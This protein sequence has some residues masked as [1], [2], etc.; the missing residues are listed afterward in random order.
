MGLRFGIL[1]LKC[2]GELGLHLNDR[3][4]N[5]QVVLTNIFATQTVLQPQNSPSPRNEELAANPRGP[6]CVSAESQAKGGRFLES[7]GRLLSG[8]VFYKIRSLELLCLSV[9]AAI[10]MAHCKLAD[11]T[12]NGRAEPIAGTGR[13]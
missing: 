10:R 12:T 7:S 5:R 9:E 11:R 3:G 13:S 4:E 1:P 8:P 6:G 2:T